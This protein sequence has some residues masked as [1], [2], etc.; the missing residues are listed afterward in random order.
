MTLCPVNCLLFP[1]YNLLWTS[2]LFSH[3]P[4]AGNAAF[5]QLSTS[6]ETAGWHWHFKGSTLPS[7]SMFWNSLQGADLVNAST[8]SWNNSWTNENSFVKSKKLVRGTFSEWVLFSDLT[9]GLP[10]PASG[11]QVFCNALHLL[12]SL[13]CFK[14]HPSRNPRG[15]YINLFHLLLLLIFR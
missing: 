11:K 6:W 14:S 13:T 4:D 2:W 15:L 3:S 7:K 9:A 1:R 8:F 12:R 10:P 5:R